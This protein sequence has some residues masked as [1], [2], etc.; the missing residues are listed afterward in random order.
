MQKERT[1]FRKEFRLRVSA[2]AILHP[3]VLI[4]ALYT[5]NFTAS[6]VSTEKIK[7]LALWRLLPQ[8]FQELPRRRGALFKS[9]CNRETV[10]SQRYNCLGVSK[11]CASRHSLNNLFALASHSI[12]ILLFTSGGRKLLNLGFTFSQVIV[13]RDNVKQTLS[14]VSCVSMNSIRAFTRI[15]FCIYFSM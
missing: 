6:D 8:A 3:E 2:H 4:T 15:L 11:F 1:S 12:L 7:T 5:F 14:A 9:S 13:S 10:L